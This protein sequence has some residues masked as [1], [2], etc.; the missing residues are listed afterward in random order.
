MTGYKTIGQGS[1]VT[2]SEQETDIQIQFSPDC[3]MMI[4]KCFCAWFIAHAPQLGLPSCKVFSLKIAPTKGVH[5][6]LSA[7]SSSQKHTVPP[8]EVKGGKKLVQPGESFKNRPYPF[9]F[10]Q[11]DNNPTDT[12]RATIEGFRSVVANSSPPSVQ[13]L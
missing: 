13:R 8:I 4:L 12:I 7:A 11:Q 5:D 2:L 9:I 10:L 3:R 1:F 6:L